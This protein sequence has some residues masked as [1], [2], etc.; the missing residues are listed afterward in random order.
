[1]TTGGTGGMDR[2][3]KGTS[4]SFSL[5]KFDQETYQIGVEAF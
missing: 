4:G 2:A 1:M 3:H 5:D